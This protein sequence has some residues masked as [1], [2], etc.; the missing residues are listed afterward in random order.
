MLSKIFGTWH[1]STRVERMMYN[2]KLRDLYFF[3]FITK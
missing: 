1:L 2:E 3:C